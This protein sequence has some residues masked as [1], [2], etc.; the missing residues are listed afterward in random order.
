MPGAGI[1][2]VRPTASNGKAA[3]ASPTA[4]AAI[5]V[6]ADTHFR[7]GSISKTFIAIALVQL[8]EDDALDLEAPVTEVAPEVA[9]ENP[10]FSR[11]AG[12]R[13]PALQHTAGFDDMHF[14]EMYNL[15]DARTSRWPRCWR[16]TRRRA[17]S[18]GGRA[19]ACR[20]RIRVT[21]SPATSWRK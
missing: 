2:L 14:N 1:A 15:D 13:P 21:G 11:I 5:P 20:I 10:W 9:I 7:V 3:S 19:R 18:A 17:A 8:Y 6:T 12:A 16:E 4:I